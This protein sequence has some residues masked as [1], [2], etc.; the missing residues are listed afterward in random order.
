MRLKVSPLR[1]TNKLIRFALML[2]L[3]QM[4][5][6]IT[7]AQD[8]SRLRISLL[9]CAPG[10]ELYSI[11]GHSAI[12]ITDSNSVSDIV[13]NF[14]TF[15][16]GEKDFYLKFM[17]GKLL[18]YLSTEDFNDFSFSY[19][20]SNR[21]IREQV[22][23]LSQEEKHLL[24]AWLNENLQENN[25]YYLYDFFLDNCTTRLR[26]LIEKIR[27][28]QPILPGAM[29]PTTSFR[30]AIHLYLEKGN[31]QWSKL[32]I[33]LL[34]GAKTDRIMTAS[35]Q[36][37]LPDN[38]MLSLDSCRNYDLVLDENNYAAGKSNFRDE[39]FSPLFFFSLMLMITLGLRAGKN[40]KLRT[41]AEGW[42]NFH[43]F[44]TGFLG[45][46][47]MLMWVATDHK[48]TK[49]NYN[50][51]WAWPVHL[52]MVFMP[53]Y[54]PI[55]KGYFRLHVTF[56]LCL[57]IAWTFLPQQLNTALIPFVIQMIVIGF[58]R[59]RKNT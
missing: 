39:W 47:L 24:Q 55:V 6:F 34:L 37:F 28:P 5:P 11:F 41:V 48:M 20:A 13:Y 32:G 23:Q 58:Y 22:L 38:L 17:R 50:L 7:K 10:D 36:Q 31:K 49:D 26:D 53:S 27:T 52:I 25:R 46:L 8:S 18:Y 3:W 12:R 42:D 57:L 56:L 40:Q 33:D 29:P 45:F 9:T 30:D 15:N 44:I 4:N 54:H 35:E 59:I 14:G 1:K 19:L 43:L 51:L 21:N 16:F 2:L